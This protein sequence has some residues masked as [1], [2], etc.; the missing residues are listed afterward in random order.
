MAGE[1]PSEE[2][3]ALIAVTLDDGCRPEMLGA[4]AKPLARELRRQMERARKANEITASIATALCASG[5]VQ[6]ISD[7]RVEMKCPACSH[8]LTAILPADTPPSSPR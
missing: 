6:S 1:E 8:E 3:L 7:T 5:V 4:A 2:I